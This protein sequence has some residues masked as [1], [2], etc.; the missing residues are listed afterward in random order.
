MIKSVNTDRQKKKINKATL[1][2]VVIYLLIFTVA[3]TYIVSV[4]N[5]YVN[6]FILA[7]NMNESDTWEVKS[8]DEN[9]LSVESAKVI[10]QDD[11]YYVHAV[12][13]GKNIGFSNIIFSFDSKGAEND[14]SYEIQY[15]VLPGNVVYNNLFDDF[16]GFE[17][18]LPAFSLMLLSTIAV[19]SVSF[20]KRRIK[21]F[22]SYK[23]VAIGGGLIYCI[24]LAL[25]FTLFNILTF[26]SVSLESFFELISIFAVNGLFLSLATFPVLLILSLLISISN[27]QLVIKEGFRVVNLLGII[28]SVALILGFSSVIF[29]WLNDF[30]WNTVSYE[31][32]S[33]VM[34]AVS[35]TFCYFSA[36]LISTIICS[37]MATRFKIKE[38]VDYII[39]LGCAIRND[40]TP[41]PILRGRIDRAIEFEKKQLEKSGKHAYFVPSGGQ[42]GNE[43]I[44]EAESM[45]NYLISQG[46]AEEQIILEDKSI[47]TAQNMEF[48]KKAIEEHCKDIDSVN[49]AFSTTN[50]HV[51]RGYTL[52][53]KVGMKVHGISAKT[54]LY[55]FPN[56]FIREFI[57]LLFSQWKRHLLFLVITIATL[58]ILMI[59]ATTL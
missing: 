27:I 32:Y 14:Y 41:T 17:V 39:I 31:V 43:V 9:V 55:F 28:L 12:F 33:V 15:T 42:G 3:A 56:A 22:F 5:V 6:D 13:R 30:D 11:F 35:Y 19:L 2:L 38:D 57:G 53:K 10:F 24:S 49:I 48:S 59:M 26:G 20:I 36:M 54:K 37:I 1:I 34:I 23:M 18:I 58:S 45:K 4:G 50:Y 21:G 29:I 25:T 8:S 16:N 51:F 47:N 44:S 46:I 52:A 40:G 7:E